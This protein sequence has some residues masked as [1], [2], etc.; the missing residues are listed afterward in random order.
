MIY[1]LLLT[2]VIIANGVPPPVHPLYGGSGWDP[3]QP[4]PFFRSLK[5]PYGIS[6]EVSHE[7]SYEDSY[8]DS[9]EGSA[10]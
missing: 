4:G 2:F 10:D 3:L 5:R 1:L 6:D 7:E 9:Y 8:E